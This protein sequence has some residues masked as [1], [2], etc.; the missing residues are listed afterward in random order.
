MSTSCRLC[1]V[2][3]DKCIAPSRRVLSFRCASWIASATY[4]ILWVWIVTFCGWSL[5]RRLRFLAFFGPWA[6]VAW[7]TAFF[8]LLCILLPC[9]DWKLLWKFQAHVAK[10]TVFLCVRASYKK[11]WTGFNCSVS[12][13]HC[14]DLWLTFKVK[15]N[16]WN[17]CWTCFKYPGPWTWNVPFLF[18][19]W[20]SHFCSCQVFV[21][22][23]R[24]QHK[25]HKSFS[26]VFFPETWSLWKSAK[27]LQ[28][29][30]NGFSSQKSAL[31][32]RYS[33][34]CL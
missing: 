15:R 8:C 3:T 32:T 4:I 17:C 26:K 19:N 33:S 34:Y 9:R 21:R 24:F 14:R 5:K 13:L 6:H 18:W 23:M 30:W 12:L 10:R 2:S 29:T 16:C 27:K 11:K 20:M 31:M 25:R 1:L 28:L 7:C 22:A